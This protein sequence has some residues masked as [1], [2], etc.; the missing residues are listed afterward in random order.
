MSITIDTYR[1]EE[2][3]PSFKA[4]TDEKEK[5]ARINAAFLNRLADDGVALN[6][7]NPI[8]IAD[9]GS[10]PCDT[11]VK[12]LTDVKF[13]PGFKVRATDYSIEYTDERNGEALA[14]LAAAKSAGTLKLV[15]FSARAGDSFAGHVL[16]LL[17][18][19]A[20]PARPHEFRIV[21]ASHVL[22]HC[23]TPGSTERLIE[24]VTQNVLADDGICILYHLAKVPLSFQD[25]RARYGSNSAAA[26]HSNTPA[27]AIDDPPAK[28]TE[29]CAA[30]GVPCLRRDFTADLR[31][32]VPD[33]KIWNYF[34]APEKYAELCKNNP[35]A[36][37]DLKRLMFITQRAPNEF[38]ADHTPTGLSAYLDEIGEVLKRNKGI[39]KLAESMQVIYR[40]DAPAGFGKRIGAA[41]SALGQA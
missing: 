2:I 7:N 15:D 3:Y 41:L 29:V 10:G 19:Q 5:T 23:E 27:V 34:R 38:A 26:A 36:A 9:I 25:F 33:E 24:D 32:A 11:L 37:E 12:Y 40:P 13:D 4:A 31:F 30:Q 1:Y 35:A 20:S 28:V 16:D 14:T 17:G 22:Y 18:S 39:L 21:F 8:A 6:G